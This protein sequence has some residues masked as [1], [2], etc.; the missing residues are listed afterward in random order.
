[1]SI[2]Y[3]SED[4][5]VVEKGKA[6]GGTGPASDDTYTIEVK[7]GD[8][9]DLV[10]LL[11]FTDEPNY[12]RK[13]IWDAFV[14]KNAGGKSPDDIAR[15]DASKQLL[16]WT[17][18]NPVFVE[19]NRNGTITTRGIGSADVFV[20]FADGLKDDSVPPQPVDLR[21]PSPGLKITVKIKT[22]SFFG[23]DGQL[24]P[25]IDSVEDYVKNA[26]GDVSRFLVGGAGWAADQVGSGIKAAEDFFGFGGT[27][28]PSPT[29][30]E[31]TLKKE[32]EAD[33][34]LFAKIIG[35]PVSSLIPSKNTIR[36]VSSAI[37][38]YQAYTAGK[39]EF[40]Q[41]KL[42]TTIKSFYD[43]ERLSISH[44]TTLCRLLGVNPKVMRR[45]S[46][47]VGKIVELEDL[48][49]KGDYEQLKDKVLSDLKIGST[50]EMDPDLRSFVN[51][52]AFQEVTLGSIVS[53][54]FTMIDYVTGTL[55]IDN[56]IADGNN[57]ILSEIEID[58]EQLSILDVSS[59]VFDF[60]NSRATDLPPTKFLTIIE[61]GLTS[62]NKTTLTINFDNPTY[63][64]NVSGTGEVKIKVK[65]TF[66]GGK[67]KPD[68]EGDEVGLLN[69]GDS[70]EE[71]NLYSALIPGSKEQSN[72]S[73]INSAVDTGTNLAKQA[74]P[75]FEEYKKKQFMT[76]FDAVDFD[77][78]PAP[79]KL[80]VINTGSQFGISE[81]EITR[82]YEVLSATKNLYDLSKKGFQNYDSL[83]PE[84]RKKF[85]DK[86]GVS[87]SLLG[88]F[89]KSGAILTDMV[90][91]KIT[92]ERREQIIQGLIDNYK[93]KFLDQFGAGGALRNYDS[94]DPKMQ[95]TIAI[96]LGFTDI[97]QEDLKN[98]KKIVVNGK[99]EIAAPRTEK[100][101]AVKKCSRAIKRALAFL[102]TAKI[103]LD[104][105]DKIVQ[106]VNEAKNKE[107]LLANE[108][109]LSELYDDIEGSIPAL[110]EIYNS[111]DEIVADPYAD[112]RDTQASVGLEDPNWR[113][114]ENIPEQTKIEE[115]EKTNADTDTGVNYGTYSI[116]TLPGVTI[117]EPDSKTGQ[118]TLLDANEPGKTFEEQF[119]INKADGIYNF[120]HEFRY[121]LSDTDVNEGSEDQLT[122]YLR[123]N[124]RM[125]ILLKG[126]I[127]K[128]FFVQSTYN[129]IVGKRT[130]KFQNDPLVYPVYI[131]DDKPN[132][133]VVDDNLNVIIPEGK[134]TTPTGVALGLVKKDIPPVEE[135]EKDSE[136]AVKGDDKTI[137]EQLQKY[138]TGK[139]KAI[140]VKD[141]SLF[142]INADSSISYGTEQKP[143]DIK[144]TKKFVKDGMLLMKFD[145]VYGNFDVSDVGLTSL[146]NCPKVVKGVFNCSKNNLESLDKSPQEVDRF[147]ADGNTKLGLKGLKGGPSKINGVTNT[148]SNQRVDIYSVVNCGLTS[149][150][151]NGIT[152]FG[153]GGFNCSNNKLQDLDGI[154][155]ISSKGVTQ[156]NCS[157]NLITSID[158]A[159]KTISDVKTGRPG[160]Y[161]I[162]DNPIKTLPTFFSNIEVDNFNCDNTEL[163]SL[164]FT[165]GKIYSNFSC[166][167]IKGKKI[168]NQSIGKDR[169]KV[170]GGFEEDSTNRIVKI[171]G[172]FVTS[173]GSWAD[174][175][176]DINTIFKAPPETDLATTNFVPSTGALVPQ[177]YKGNALSPLVKLP[178]D[179][180]YQEVSLISVLAL[181]NNIKPYTPKELGYERIESAAEP[182]TYV[183]P[184][185]K[186]NGGKGDASL[187]LGTSGKGGVQYQFSAANAPSGN[188]IN[189]SMFESTA[190]GWASNQP[191][192]ATIINGKNYGAKTANRKYTPVMYWLKGDPHPKVGKSSDIFVAKISDKP[193]AQNP[194]KQASFIN[195]ITIC[196][197]AANMAYPNIPYVGKDSD[198]A[199]VAQVKDANGKISYFVGG[200]TGSNYSKMKPI[201]ESQGKQIIFYQ[202]ADPGGSFWFQSGGEIHPKK[203]ERGYP[204]CIQW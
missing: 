155:I 86:L 77:K 198:G 80:L 12:P 173:E 24:T 111:P 101:L 33:Q 133:A 174:K 120:K 93:Q 191:T 99:E 119:S 68:A 177:Q 45:L 103:A 91:G 193:H 179:L 36:A 23:E 10:N 128:Q 85:A 63:D 21:I 135:E 30:L 164:S 56:P 165:P 51:G 97:V 53:K 112:F 55:E 148:N 19:V 187:R 49:K 74:V 65:Y 9:F 125:G 189:W 95:S 199:F 64:P 72:S 22:N 121:A 62:G 183:N 161:I 104:L 202:N 7:D 84:L 31:N 107:N 190:T 42:L 34:D 167:G 81:S 180:W 46:Y 47:V 147:I 140:E 92:G 163:I 98:P 175:S 108:E 127:N 160:N 41:A 171:D 145:T 181:W 73:K 192:G 18:S 43:W 141:N 194:E 136:P 40:A 139:T 156:F 16:S 50:D 106:R 124:A 116:Y 166:K 57:L 132:V 66:V 182:G 129:I 8:S 27:T 28:I 149:L 118:I 38:I 89:V 37:Q 184:S 137:R 134:R 197:P 4:P 6:S 29:I 153:P 114:K 20:N 157:K 58:S 186:K 152:Q 88:D 162:S 110:E 32:E 151:D 82:Y 203:K 96:A 131:G 130:G 54:K 146:E 109:F 59:D 83:P 138:T 176:Y 75:V 70:S 126:D 79:V 3:K 26:L 144:I 142:K 168:T 15:K 48:V 169:F 87:E 11:E 100:G 67:P 200:S 14:K 60:S 1:M 2:K 76:I 35:I 117:S 90:S 172:N 122:S 71:N 115:E 159:P 94:L 196:V 154:E 188:W 178:G 44:K 204:I 185:G 143:G 39:T 102:N 78:L 52:E 5:I 113:E 150:K 201:I 61:G 25:M 195:N 158:K 13:R 17:S 123:A 69:E 105:K 170:G